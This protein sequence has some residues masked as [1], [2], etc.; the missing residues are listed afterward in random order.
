MKKKSFTDF[1][2]RHGLGFALT[3]LV[4]VS[5]SISLTVFLGVVLAW[6]WWEQIR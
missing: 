2:L 6:A 3:F 5:L 4:I 1:L